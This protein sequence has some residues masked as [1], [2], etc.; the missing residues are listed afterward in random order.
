M[1]RPN[2]TRRT[3]AGAVMVVTGVALA[4]TIGIRAQQQAPAAPAAIDPSL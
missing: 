4:A 2:E 3:M 1:N